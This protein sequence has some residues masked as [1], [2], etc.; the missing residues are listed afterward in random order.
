MEDLE[1]HLILGEGSGFVSEQVGDAAQLLRDGGGA[2]H[3]ALHLLI[4]VDH[5]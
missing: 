5:P 2:D 1:D 3:C 4:A